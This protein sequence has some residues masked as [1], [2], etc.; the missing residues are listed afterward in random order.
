MNNYAQFSESYNDAFQDDNEAVNT[1]I[2]HGADYV[3]SELQAVGQT[4]SLSDNSSQQSPQ[5]L[6]DTSQS[7]SLENSPQTHRSPMANSP[8][9]S[10]ILA[11]KPDINC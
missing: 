1:G 3:N 6:I 7:D 5:K 9:D 4:Q 10:S 8:Y 11:V 2:I